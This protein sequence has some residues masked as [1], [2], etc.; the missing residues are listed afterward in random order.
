MRTARLTVRVVVVLAV[1]AGLA[2]GQATATVGPLTLDVPEGWLVTSREGNNMQLANGTTGAATSNEAGTA[3]AVFDIYL[4]SDISPS[5]YAERLREDN[6]GVSEEKTTVGGEDA[7][8]LS[9]EGTA[10]AGKQEAVFIPDREIRIVYRA[11]FGGDDGSFFAG[12]PAF[13]SAV[14]SIRFSDA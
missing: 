11:A 5:E 1:F 14:R 7:V 2:C 12:R 13:R 9:Y 6:V 3:K 4:E 8:I 10:V